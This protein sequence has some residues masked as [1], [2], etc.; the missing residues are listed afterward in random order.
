M[1]HAQCPRQIHAWCPSHIYMHQ[2]HGHRRDMATDMPQASTASILTPLTLVQADDRR[3]PGNSHMSQM[4]QAHV[5]VAG[6]L[7]VMETWPTFNHHTDYT[8]LFVPFNGTYIS[9]VWP[10]GSTV[11]TEDWA[12]CDTLCPRATGDPPTCPDGLTLLPYDQCVS[13]CMKV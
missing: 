12:C 7:S 6:I 13:Q 3:N 8:G 1:T 2:V 9:V 5:S 4:G 11:A 10:R